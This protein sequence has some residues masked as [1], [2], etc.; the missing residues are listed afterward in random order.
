MATV[1]RVR[2]VWSGF[3]GAPGYSN[4]SFQD[5]TT[6]TSRNNAG[7][8]VKAFFTA[9]ANHLSTAWTVSVLGEITEWDMATGQLTGASTM[10]TIPTGQVGTGTP[11]PYAGGSGLCVTW[12]TGVIFQGRRVVGRTFIVPALGCYEAD[13][14]L[15][16]GAIAAANTAANGL[17]G[18]TGAEFCIWAKQ[19]TKPTDGTK[20]VQVGGAIAPVTSHSTKDMAS[21]LRSRRL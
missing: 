17:I 8:A 18:A 15:T 6:E 3:Q 4:F 19:F 10:T 21:Q 5:L 9:L 1:Y 14:T 11:A 13:G 2:A 16:A 7:A 20:P 12:K